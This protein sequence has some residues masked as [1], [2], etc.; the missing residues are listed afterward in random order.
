[1]IDLFH[2]FGAVCLLALA[3]KVHNFPNS[4]V[5]CRPTLAFQVF[6]NS[7]DFDLAVIDDFD[8]LADCAPVLLFLSEVYASNFGLGLNADNGSVRRDDLFLVNVLLLLGERDVDL[9]ERQKIEEFLS[10]EKQVRV[11]HHS[12]C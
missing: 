12:A 5:K 9:G 2:L 1:M 8:R 4:V 7:K 3:A 6:S 10:V 11:Y